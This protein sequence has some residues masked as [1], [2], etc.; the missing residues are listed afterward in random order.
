LGLTFWGAILLYI[1]PSKH[2]PLQL[3]NAVA[4]SPMLNIERVLEE[5]D[6]HEKGIYLSPKHL[7][8]FESSLIFIPATAEQNLPTPE[9]TSQKKLYSQNPIGALLTPPGLALSMLFEKELGMSF[10]KIDL[11]TLEEKLPK[12][13]VENLELAEQVEV[14]SQGN[15]V[16]ISIRNT[17]LNQIC[18]ETRNLQKV[19]N[20]IGNV[21]SSALACAL[22]K[23]T[24]KSVTI[25]KE[26]LTEDGKNAQIELHTIE[27]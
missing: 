5:S 1:T 10:T 17:V 7:T 21:L 18:A 8:D 27:E 15:K 4:T 23:T 26:E 19:H 6:L 20:Q 2:V 24:G 22:A 14:K 25:E 11:K 9:Q 3:L 16:N 13:L 12:L